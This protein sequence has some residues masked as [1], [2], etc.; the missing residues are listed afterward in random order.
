MYDLKKNNELAIKAARENAHKARI[1]AEK[2][3]QEEDDWMFIAHWLEKENVYEFIDRL[4]RV[5]RLVNRFE[6]PKE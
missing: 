2:F 6:V 4:K 5:G 3:G 1:K